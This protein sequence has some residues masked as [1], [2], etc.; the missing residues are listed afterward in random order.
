MCIYYQ[1]VIVDSV[2]SWCNSG[3]GNDAEELHH[4]MNGVRR[5][6]LWLPVE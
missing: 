1:S 3:Q 4:V 6:A 5:V 2:Q